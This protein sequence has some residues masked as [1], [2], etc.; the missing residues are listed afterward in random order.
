MKAN[1][2]VTLNRVKYIGSFLPYLIIRWLRFNKSF[3]EL[4]LLGF[5]FV[6]V[7]PFVRLLNFILILILLLFKDQ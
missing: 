1:I 7:H 4:F 5:V 2:L 3:T 6:A